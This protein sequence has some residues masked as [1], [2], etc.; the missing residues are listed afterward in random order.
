MC[1]ETNNIA[2]MILTNGKIITVDKHFSIAKAVAIRNEK[3][4]AVG[5]M[6]DIEKHF[7]NSHSKS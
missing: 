4:I 1:S 7:Q 2:D 3:I 6:P 5:S